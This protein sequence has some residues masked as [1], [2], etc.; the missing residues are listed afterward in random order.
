VVHAVHSLAVGGMENGLVNVVR[1]LHGKIRQ[2]VVCVTET[3]PLARRLPG[4]V[5]VHCLGK[6]PGLDPVA[7]LR[8]CRLLRRLGPDIVHSRNWGALDAVA[9]ARL[10]GVPLVVHGEHGREASDPAGA[11]ARRNRIR[12]VLAPWVDRFVAVSCDLGRWLV[13]TVRIEPLKVVTIHN[14]VDTIRFSEEGREGGRRAL[15]VRPDEVVIGTVGRLD[16]VK[17]QLGLLEAFARLARDGIERRL[18]VVGTGPCREAL[19]RRASRPDLGGRVRLLGERLDVPLLLKGFDVFALP[20]VAEGIS[21]TLLEAMATGLP[22]VA[23]RA[24]GNPELVE[25]GVTGTLVRV[26]DRVDLARGL[27]GYVTDP[28]LRTLHGKA[29]RRRAVELFGL[30]RMVARYRDLYLGLLARRAT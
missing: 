3:G 21:N 5:V 15:G 2:V 1:G 25:D 17:D 4:D 7:V 29:G 9:A 28:G 19:E 20:S 13:E 11:S 26:G 23:T 22:V 27:D 24:G 10:A 18:V 12:R 30:N 16:P 8:L 14:G 6:G